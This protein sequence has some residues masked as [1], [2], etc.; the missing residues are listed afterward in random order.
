MIFSN[1][2]KTTLLQELAAELCFDTSSL[3][4]SLPK[5]LLVTVIVSLVCRVVVRSYKN[6]RTRLISLGFRSQSSEGYHTCT[7]TLS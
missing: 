2:A 1:E 5:L 3:R 6:L 7:G 4:L